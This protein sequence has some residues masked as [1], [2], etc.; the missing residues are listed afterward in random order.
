MS[1]QTSLLSIP[2]DRGGATASNRLDYQKNWALCKLLEIHQNSSSNYLII[3]DLHEDVIVVHY[4]GDQPSKASFYQVKTTKQEHWTWRELVKLYNGKSKLGKLYKKRIKFGDSAHELCFVSNG[5]YKVTMEEPNRK[6]IN[7]R[8]ICLNNISLGD[9]EEIIKK[10]AAELKIKV[11]EIKPDIVFL[12]RSDLG[13]GAHAQTTRGKLTD[14]LEKFLKQENPRVGT[15]YRA[16]AGEIAQKTNNE[17]DCTTFEELIKFHAISREQFDSILR[18]IASSLQEDLWAEVHQ[19]LTQEL[20]TLSERSK[21]KSQWQNYK[22]ERMDP[23]NLLVTKLKNSILDII[24][25]LASG[26]PESCEELLGLGVTQ[27]NDAGE[28]IKNIFELDYIKAAILFEFHS[29]EK[30]S[31]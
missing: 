19:S 7:L 15:V 17:L 14:F 9:R 11:E 16:L 12:A 1:L 8:K 30:S 6:A 26:Q 31:T 29:N 13:I 28:E 10:L 3:L 20:F 23:S 2:D 24:S 25:N 18:T 22:V 5:Y 21:I 27:L 4:E